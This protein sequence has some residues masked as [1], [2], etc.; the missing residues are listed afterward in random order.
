MYSEV[1]IAISLLRAD[2][3]YNSGIWKFTR[4]HPLLS[5]WYTTETIYPHHF[6]HKAKWMPFNFTQTA[7]LTSLL[8][9]LFYARFVSTYVQHV[10]S[11]GYVS[12]LR[13]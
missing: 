8:T 9:R 1:F 4:P 3:F 7:P 13:S 6:V 10:L 2:G 11:N 12:W 5:I